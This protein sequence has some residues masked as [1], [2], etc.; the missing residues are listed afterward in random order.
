MPTD[1]EDPLAAA[2]LYMA[3][4]NGWNAGA[5]A[6][7]MDV[8]TIDHGNA[9]LRTAYIEGYLAGD[10]ARDRAARHAADHY[11]F[12]SSSAHTPSNH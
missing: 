5:A 2:N 12:R 1:K 8:K 6:R 7:G 11:R 10:V 3:Y 9:E 4:C